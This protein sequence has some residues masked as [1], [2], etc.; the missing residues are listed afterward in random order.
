MLKNRILLIIIL[1]LI[2]TIPS[3]QVNAADNSAT[4]IINMKDATGQQVY[5]YYKKVESQS[6]TK[7]AVI[8]ISKILEP[9]FDEYVPLGLHKP[10]AL[11]QFF[12]ESGFL[13]SELSRVGNNPFG[14]KGTGYI[15]QTNE[16]I[17][18]KEVF[19]NLSFEAFENFEEG[20]R[21]Y[22]R[23]MMK[24]RYL[25]VRQANNFVDAAKAIKECGYASDPNYVGDGYIIN[26]PIIGMLDNIEY[27]DLYQFD[28][29]PFESSTRD[30]LI[31]RDIRQQSYA[32]YLLNGYYKPRI[33]AIQELLT[34]NGFY[35]NEIDGWYGAV[36]KAS[37]MDYQEANDLYV[38]GLVGI[39]TYEAFYKENFTADLGSLNFE[40]DAT[41]NNAEWNVEV[42]SYLVPDNSKN[43]PF[44]A[45]MMIDNNTSTCWIPNGNRSG[46]GE[47]ITLSL[48]SEKQASFDSV[49]I[50]A[51]Y[52]KSK[53]HYYTNYRIKNISV[54]I[55]EKYIGDFELTDSR[56][57]QSI[58]LGKEYIGSKV[59]I[60][61]NSCYESKSYYGY[62]AW[63]DLCVSEISIDGAVLE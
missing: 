12:M 8:A 23:L 22:C 41:E 28:T 39:Y 40:D 53:A 32:Q 25:P 37:V 42:S 29:N 21:G 19:L 16:Y 46:I 55:D 18:G 62:K 34:S 4:D 36:S 5:D 63:E 2:L 48:T 9:I 43:G 49:D 58:Y 14:I 11:A 20:V 10:P 13:S 54:Y 1:I 26:S 35:Q 51:G 61:I 50:F 60:I 45:D 31:W 59:E 17:D 33:I 38:D 7:S 27:Y 24:D 30:E 52:G 56:I 47:S 6:G 15:G 57:K 3:F 44:T